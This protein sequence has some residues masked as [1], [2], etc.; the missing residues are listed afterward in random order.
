M[1]VTDPA[2]ILRCNWETE[3]KENHKNHFHLNKTK[4]KSE[5]LL[6]NRFSIMIIRIYEIRPKL[7]FNN[8]EQTR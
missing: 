3:F 1:F 8:G 7:F 2:P 4:T 6:L 5:K